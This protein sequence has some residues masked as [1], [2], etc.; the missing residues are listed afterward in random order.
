MKVLVT[1]GLGNIGGNVIDELTNLHHEIVVFDKENKKTRKSHKKLSK[2]YNYTLHWGDIT[3]AE[4]ITPALEGID[5]IIHLAA[6]LSPVSERIPEIAHKVNVEGTRNLVSEAKKANSDLHL[7]FS[8]SFAVYGPRM[9]HE[10]PIKV[11]D[12]FNLTDHY[13]HHKAECEKMITESSL[14]YTFI[15]FGAVLPLDVVSEGV[16]PFAFEIPMDQRIH[17]IH[18]K[19]AARALTHAVDRKRYNK[20]YLG[21]GGADCSLLQGDL[22]RRSL[23]ATGMGMFPDKAFKKAKKPG[24]YIYF[25]WMDTE[26][27]ERDLE[28]QQLTYEDYVNDLKEFLG[29]KRHFAKMFS[30][31][32]KYFILRKSPYMKMKQ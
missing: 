31:I 1:G 22:L 2:K 11:D 30:P 16:D 5:A 18:H 20:I 32:V 29:Y 24:D 8:S 12:P 13:S 21:G 15:R 25:D 10:P 14:K 17:F 23:T 4:T 9:D 26:E 19:D 6:I 28:F 27:S 7:V 3:R